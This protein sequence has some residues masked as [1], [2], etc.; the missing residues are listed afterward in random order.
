[1]SAKSAPNRTVAIIGG[2]PAGL[3]AA[4]VLCQGG[5]QVDLYEAMPSAGRKLLMAG[6]GGLNLTHAEPEDLFRSRYGEHGKNIAPFLDD[7]GPQDVRA[8]AHGLGIETFVGS[9]GRVFP[10]E[11]KAAPLLR[12]WLRTLRAAGAHL[13]VRHRWRGW[14]P[15]SGMLRFDTPKGSVSTGADAVVLALGGGSWPQLG[16]DGAWVELLRARGVEIKTLRPA[17]C[18]FDVSWSDYFRERFAG[19]PVKSVAVVFKDAAGAQRRQQGEFVISAAGI[20]GGLIYSFSAAARDE[21]AA[22]GKA[23]IHVDLRPDRDLQRLTQDLSRP[24]GKTS[25]ANTLRKCAGIEGVK[26]GLL[27]EFLRSEDFDDH[28]R[29]AAAIKALPIPLAAPRPLAESIS[30]AGGVDFAALTG[31]LMIRALPSVFCAGEMLDWEAPTGGY[32]LT[33]CL[34]TGRSAGR[35][36]LAWLERNSER[37]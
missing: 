24:R 35:G 14:D 33:A 16:S 3:M 8:W 28:R 34:A 23:I 15:T 27:R 5:V 7:F 6:K 10:S 13:H 37:A 20:E 21:I 9:S 29:L 18:G 12:A 17:N 2:G 22:S 25:L 4:D 31:D 32:L 19:H 1:M 26:A 11:M 36:A 30:S